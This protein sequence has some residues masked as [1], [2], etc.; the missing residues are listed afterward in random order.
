[1]RILLLS[2]IS[3]LLLLCSCTTSRIYVVRHAEKET[4]TT[5]SDVP[6][7]AAGAQ[8]AQ[9]L[10]DKLGNKKI[11]QIYST[12]YVRT[13]ATAQ[14][15]ADSKHITIAIY[16]PSDTS[17]PNRL[18]SQSKNILVVGHSNTVDDLINRITMQSTVPGDLPDTQYGD[19]FILTKK[20]GRFT[21]TRDHF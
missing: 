18:R 21:L 14:P 16:N 1:M 7:S 4:Q 19:L 11:D 15:L 17:F 13:K 12:N 10:K 2:L 8:R 6:L 3:G 5:V 9:A 20:R